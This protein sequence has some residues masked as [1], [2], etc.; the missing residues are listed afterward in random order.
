MPHGSDLAASV[1]LSPDSPRILEVEAE[2]AN[3]IVVLLDAPPERLTVA[4]ELHGFGMPGAHLGAHFEKVRGQPP[5][6][7]Y[8]IEARGWLTD[9][10]GLARLEVPAQAFERI[11]VRVG[12]GN[13]QVVDA[14]RA[15]V[16]RGGT[17]QLELR[18]GQGTVQ[19]ISVDRRQKA[20]LDMHES[21][22]PQQPS[23]S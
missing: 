16:A 23:T 1:P 6:L 15:G 7:R 12:R 9:V 20:G 2:R 4:G 22:S 19:R 8:S 13:I 18:T 10:D 17:V 3:I 5:A 14:T 11:R 21:E